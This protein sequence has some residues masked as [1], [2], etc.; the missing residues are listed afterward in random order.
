VLSEEVLE[1][2]ERLGQWV[3]GLVHLAPSLQRLK[4]ARSESVNILRHVCDTDAWNQYLCVEQDQNEWLS[5]ASL[6]LARA[7]FRAGQLSALQPQG[8]VWRTGQ[9]DPDGVG[10]SDPRASARDG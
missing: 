4:R 1:D 8:T 9:S 7:A 2:D 3:D 10:Q 6:L 5:E